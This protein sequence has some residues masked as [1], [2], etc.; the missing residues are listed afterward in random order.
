MSEFSSKG[1]CLSDA[2]RI[3]C[4]ITSM[5]YQQKLTQMMKKML[6]KLGDLSTPDAGGFTEL[7]GLDAGD[8]D[9]GSGSI[10]TSC[11]N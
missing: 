7:G 5:F 8:A 3:R 1:T 2:S 10:A 11:G 4:F 9:S 6:T